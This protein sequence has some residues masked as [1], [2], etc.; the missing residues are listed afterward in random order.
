MTG[1]IS[2]GGG[3][4][5]EMWLHELGQPLEEK[6][7]IYEDGYAANPHAPPP[8]NKIAPSFRRTLGMGERAY[9]LGANVV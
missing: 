6:A 1:T 8:R 7:T 3:C 5:A 4:V 9:S 2:G